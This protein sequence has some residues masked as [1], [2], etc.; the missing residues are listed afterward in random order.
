MCPDGSDFRPDAAADRR[1]LR[2][3]SGGL[4][5]ICGVLRAVPEIGT[6][7][8]L[9][10]RSLSWQPFGRKVLSGAG[11]GSIFPC[12]RERLAA[13]PEQSG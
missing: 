11:L 10:I 6:L 9:S 8:G 1:E 7:P 4:G 12:F 3:R 5:G 13:V 2:V